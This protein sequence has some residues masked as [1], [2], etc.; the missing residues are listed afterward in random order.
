M[1]TALYHLISASK[2]VISSYICRASRQQNSKKQSCHTQY[3][4]SRSCPP[5]FESFHPFFILPALK[6]S[7]K[8]K[9]GTNPT[10]PPLSH[11]SLSL[12][13]DCYALCTLA[14]S[15]ILNLCFVSVFF[16]ER[17]INRLLIAHHFL[18]GRCKTVYQ[19]GNHVDY[20]ADAVLILDVDQTC[21]S[22]FNQKHR[23]GD[24]LPL[25]PPMP[26]FLRESL[27]APQL[28][29][30]PIPNDTSTSGIMIVSSIFVASPTTVFVVKTDSAPFHQ[31]FHYRS[32]IVVFI[33]CH[34]MLPPSCAVF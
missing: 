32:N 30:A 11:F 16:R 14:I 21:L 22:V 27:P 19:I 17:C 18:F 20:L 12:I 5:V 29:P 24:I 7:S 9:T 23:A 15:I 2:P 4:G 10:R 3:R 34:A 25:I 8:S 1:K 13:P 31:G 26:P 28:A 6:L 33:F